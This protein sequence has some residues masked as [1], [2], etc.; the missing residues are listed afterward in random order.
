MYFF[1]LVM[2]N[3]RNVGLAA[4]PNV[5][6]AAGPNVGLAAGPDVGLAAGP[7]VGLAARP[8]VGLAA[9]PNVGLAARPDV[10]LASKRNVLYPV[11]Q[12]IVLLTADWISARSVASIPGTSM[13]SFISHLLLPGSRIGHQE[14]KPARG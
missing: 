1:T 8:D 4:G 6:L 12:V 2:A 13:M 5:G 14:V 11:V 9:G 10:G 3:E 7:N